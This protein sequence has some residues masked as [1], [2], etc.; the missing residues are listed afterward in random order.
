MRQ[1]LGIGLL[2]RQY[3]GRKSR[4]T[5]PER[6]EKSAGGLIRHILQVRH[7]ARP[8]GII[9][10]FAF[11]PSIRSSNSGITQCMALSTANLPHALFV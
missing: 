4:G 9:S 3:G 7:E 2:R 6:F 8:P 10:A 5:C 1:G 11:G